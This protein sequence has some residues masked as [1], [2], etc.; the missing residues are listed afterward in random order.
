[1]VEEDVDVVVIGGGPAG[2]AYAA[3]TARAG[4]SVRIVEGK[5]FPRHH[6]GESLLAMSI[7][8]L[9]EIGVAPLL[10]AEG[11]LPKTGAVFVWGRDHKRIDL[12]FPAPGLAYQVRR[13]RFDQILLDHAAVSGARVS[14]GQWVRGLLR[15]T[16]GRVCGVVSEGEDGPVTHRARL[17]VDASGL[18]QFLPK[19]LGLTV[20]VSGPRRVA[21]SGY[22]E[23]AARVQGEQANNVISEAT[24]DGWLWFIPLDE[25]VT[26]VGFVGDE[27]DL[28]EKP[29]TVLAEQIAT[30]TLVASLLEGSTP[31]G[32]ARLLRYTNHIVA[33][34]LWHD[35]CVLVGDTAFFVDPLFSTGVHGAL[36]SGVSAAAATIGL[37]CDGIAE[38]DV[39]DWYD[40]GIRKHYRRVQTM[41][42]LLYGVNGGSSRFWTERDL[43]AMD[44]AEAQR[45]FNDLGDIS[46]PLFQ[47]WQ[48]DGAL[49]MPAALAALLDDARPSPTTKARLDADTIALS[50]GVSVRPVLSRHGG[51]LAS[52]LGVF[53]E[54]SDHAAVVVRADSPAVAL[55]RALDRGR[56]PRSLW[57]DDRRLES[58]VSLLH[59]SGLID[60]ERVRAGVV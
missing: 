27:S 28:S 6:I 8:L 60:A 58:L 16:A 4:L 14:H 42:R 45:I 2:S 36:H 53:G 24:R 50:R 57:Q 5:E 26:S 15:D 7:P 55:V 46:I 35:G 11:F 30:S 1:M 54:G 49:P 52:A 12:G 51:R 18:F 31:Q 59:S 48:R 9:E 20:D 56:T 13:A 37:L 19:R 43:S 3:I 10:A 47:G 21:I 41:V 44:P 33:D 32:N 39:A 23:H 25:H 34:P 22:Y 17:V 38:A 29:H 40:S